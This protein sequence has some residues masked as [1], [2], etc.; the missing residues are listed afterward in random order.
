MNICC[1]PR[2]NPR[3]LALDLDRCL[4]CFGV[5]HKVVVA[6]R[7]VLVAA[8][9]QCPSHHNLVSATYASSNSR[10]SFRKAFLHFL[11]MKVMS[12]VCV[13]GWSDC[14]WWHSAQSNHFLP[15]HDEPLLYYRHMGGRTA[16]R[17]DGDLGVEDVFAARGISTAERLRGRAGGKRAYHMA[18]LLAVV[19]TMALSIGLQR[20]SFARWLIAADASTCAGTWQGLGRFTGSGRIHARPTSG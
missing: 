4:W 10:A 8:P 15:G 2:V 9:H 14:S 19:R 16:R 11:Q 1:L 3:I 12:K 5:Q 18:R 17:A 6:M 20:R 7:A 13:S